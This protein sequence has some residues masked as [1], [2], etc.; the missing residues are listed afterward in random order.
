MLSV[1]S[2]RLCENC[3]TIHSL[4]YKT[5]N[6]TWSRSQWPRD[7]RRVS[8]ADCLLGLWV[9]IPPGAWMSLLSVMCCQVDVSASGWSLVQRSPTECGV[10]CDPKA[11][12]MRVPGSREAVAPLEVG[13][14]GGKKTFC[15]FVS[16][17]RLDKSTVTFLS[18]YGLQSSTQYRGFRSPRKLCL[19][20]GK[21]VPTFRWYHLNGGNCLPGDMV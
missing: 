19:F 5:N 4:F 17:I 7:P 1:K 18:K 2:S 10:V 16:L 6:I 14:G 3:N 11:S 12:I 21:Y 15:S 20:F 9:R 8:S 13:K